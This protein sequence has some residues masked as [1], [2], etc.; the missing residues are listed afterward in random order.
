MVHIKTGS[1]PLVNWTIPTQGS[2]DVTEYFNPE[3]G[4]AKFFWSGS[5]AKTLTFWDM[6]HLSQDSL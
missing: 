4:K 6:T 3:D 2:G 5:D 1:V